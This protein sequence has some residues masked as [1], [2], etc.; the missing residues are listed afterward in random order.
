MAAPIVKFNN[1]LDINRSGEVNQNLFLRIDD[2]NDLNAGDKVIIANQYGGVLD[3]F[4]GNPIYLCAR[5]Y[6]FRS[7]M[8]DKYYLTDSLNNY[9]VLNVGKVG[10]FFTFQFTYTYSNYW[11]K[12]ICKDK[13]LCYRQSDGTW[14][15]KQG[16]VYLY[17]DL[18]FTNNSSD[19][20]AQWKF[21]PNSH[22]GGFF[23][24]QRSGEE[25]GTCINYE[26]G[27]TRNRFWYG[28]HS[29]DW[30]TYGV[31]LYKYVNLDD[32]QQMFNLNN[33]SEPNRTTFYQGEE[34]DLSGLEF[35]VYLLDKDDD[36]SQSGG[37]IAS[38]A[39]FTIHSR[40]ENE[41]NLYSSISVSGT[42]N[43]AIATF[44][45]MGLGYRVFITIIQESTQTDQY[46][47]LN[48]SMLDYRGTYYLGL[49]T[50]DHPVGEYGVDESSYT[51]DILNGHETYLGSVNDSLSIGI[52]SDILDVPT[53]GVS[54]NVFRSKFEV[55]RVIVNNKSNTYLYNPFCEKYVS[56][57]DENEL[58]CYVEASE[59]S[60]KEIFS[61]INNSP[62]LNSNRY[63]VFGNYGFSVSTNNSGAIR[64]FKLMPKSSFYTAL[65]NFK[66]TFFEKIQCLSVG[67][68][69]FSSQDW[70]DTK[71]AFD[72]L[73]V[74]AQGYLAN[75]TYTHNL[76][77]SG[78][79]NDLVDRYDYILSKYPS[80][81]DDYMDRKE[82]A[83]SNYY[84]SSQNILINGAFKQSG[85]TIVI[86][87]AVSLLIM[88]SIMFVRKR[89]VD[90]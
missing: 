33:I 36:I 17:G 3:H 15:D 66:D 28:G 54:P 48:Y 50:S 12:V 87:I 59:L 65:D 26:S 73:S 57:N 70:L 16:K 62:V 14:D 77:E 58:L 67:E 86:I 46:H 20:N 63:I 79:L 25:Y 75:L 43:N 61:V 38:N 34:V 5:D 4:G 78:S 53:S 51:V 11:D 64:M 24:M 85:N 88:V 41:K 29:G 45:Y 71:T 10:N 19:E 68:T 81:Y 1:T 52:T 23:D 18:Y 83:Y 69:N 55:K 76:E 37:D 49:I 32:Y 44:T 84:T 31:R 6:D 8:G 82:A 35:N 40:Y 80:N 13:Y 21:S 60:E 27:G 90:R 74:D 9:Q 56:Y 7:E 47:L 72:S 22:G 30:S 89:K 2:I 42:G 39:L